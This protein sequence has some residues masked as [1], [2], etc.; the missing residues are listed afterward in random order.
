MSKKYKFQKNEDVYLTII[1]YFE[2]D[3]LLIKDNIIK[4]LA[5]DKY[6]G[7]TI[8]P[9]DKNII[10]EL[11]K[12]KKVRDKDDWEIIPPNWANDKKKVE[13]K[14][15]KLFPK[16]ISIEP[17]KISSSEKIKTLSKKEGYK[18]ILEQR[19]AYVN[20]I[21]SEFYD[22]II[23]ESDDPKIKNS[24]QLFVKGYL[25]LESPFRGLLVYH[26]LGT[27]KTATS[28][29]TAE[30]LSPLPI[31]TFLP[32]SL[33][34]NYIAEIKKF[35]SDTFNIESNNWVFFTLD[36]IDKNNVIRKYI[37]DE[38]DIEKKI[39]DKIDRKIKLKR[40]KEGE[41]PPKKEKKILTLDDFK[42][43]MNVS[44]KHKGVITEGIV[45]GLDK[46]SQKVVVKTESKKLRVLPKKLKIID[47]QSESEE[48][49]SDPIKKGLFINLNIIGNTDK[50]IFT[51]DGEFKVSKINKQTS[52]DNIQKL[53]DIQMKQLEIQIDFMIESKYNFIH[54]NPF[55]SITRDQIKE[56]N[57]DGDLYDN[58]LDEKD[59]KQ[60]TSDTIKKLI[61]KYTVNKKLNIDSPFK[62]EV[63]IFDEVHNFI[64]F[65]RY[66]FRK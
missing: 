13:E 25:S 27:G 51:V 43:D 18:Y 50:T 60:K 33:E 54:Y 64:R 1:K 57:I 32:A 39:L 65:N 46:E 10:K 19:K 23:D 47:D 31:N 63:I 3:V 42:P 2:G 55:P 58:I 56:L 66:F 53:S 37:Y 38:I 22:K 16:E 29:I 28:V 30:G 6:Q 61:E 20:W 62:N 41:G 5:N 11:K 59:D 17:E 44:Y 45:D 34:G 36:E 26:G 14:L 12:V 49:P 8:K 24:Y 35:A 9:L 40:R 52:T 21:N 48:E 15:N 7:E 4:D